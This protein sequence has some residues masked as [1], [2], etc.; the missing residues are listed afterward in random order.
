[1]QTESA[2]SLFLSDPVLAIVR[3]FGLNATPEL[4]E[5]LQGGVGRALARAHAAVAAELPPSEASFG[6][7][8]DAAAVAD[9][10]GASACGPWGA[11]LHD[12]FA[13]RIVLR[14]ALCRAVFA[15]VARRHVGPPAAAK[16]ESKAGSY[17]DIAPECPGG[18]GPAKHTRMLP[19]ALPELPD[20]LGPFAEQLS[21]DVNLLLRGVCKVDC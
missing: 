21:E 19:R 3:V 4:I 18:P 20:A 11:V 17:G 1:M 12:L 15:R 9:A 2:F 13:N 8:T 7:A 14:F 10:W 6:A 16:D 5:A